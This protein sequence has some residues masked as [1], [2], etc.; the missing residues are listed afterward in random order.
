M[1]P[2]PTPCPKCGALRKV[3]KVMMT[4]SSYQ[5][6]CVQGCDNWTANNVGTAKI[7]GYKTRGGPRGQ[8]A[9]VEK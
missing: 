3:E 8:I 1:K 2:D 4:K 7:G 9:E 5:Q 6:W